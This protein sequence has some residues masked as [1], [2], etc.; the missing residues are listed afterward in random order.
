[1]LDGFGALAIGLATVRLG[2][3]R[4]RKGDPVDPAVGIV[5]ALDAGDPVA[6]GEPIA[7]VHARDTAA[8]DAAAAEVL[9]AAR[10]VDGP[11]DVPPVVIET[12]D[13]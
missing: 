6:A 1:M 11:V 2:A 8:A 13:H 3:G 9:A 7:W 10:I 5:L 12:I 4:A